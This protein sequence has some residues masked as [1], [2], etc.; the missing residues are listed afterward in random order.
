V[1]LAAAVSKQGGA[2]DLTAVI[3]SIDGSDVTNLSYASA[4]NLGLTQHSPFGIA[5]VQSPQ[6]KTFTIGFPTPLRFEK[7]LRLS[8]K[9]DEPN[10]AHIVAHVIHGSAER[11]IRGGGSRSPGT[12]P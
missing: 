12:L 4:V 11:E 5:V 6:V 10:V 9:V 3:L 8:V 1:F 2:N 7:T